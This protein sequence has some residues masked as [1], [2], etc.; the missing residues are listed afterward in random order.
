MTS[1]DV[2][3][4][5]LQDSGVFADGMSADAVRL[6][7][8]WQPAKLRAPMLYLVTADNASR[9]TRLADFEAMGSSARQRVVLDIP[10]P[11]SH[12][13]LASIGFLRLRDRDTPRR[14][15]FIEAL[16]LQHAFFDR[17]VRRSPPLRP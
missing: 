9:E 16:D 7:A 14:R 10:A 15:A 12:D 2:R 11:A 5:S 3:A 13:D 4:I 17:Y 8:S 6:S 1:S